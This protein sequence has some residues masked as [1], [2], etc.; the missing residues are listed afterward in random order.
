[1]LR[2]RQSSGGRRFERL[3]CLLLELAGHTVTP[4]LQHPAQGRGDVD[5][6]KLGCSLHDQLADLHCASA[7]HYFP[8]EME[9]VGVARGSSAPG[10]SALPL[11]AA[12]AVDPSSIDMSNN[13][14]GQESALNL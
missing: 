8:V 14:V 11:A 1:V 13:D 6:I 5:V 12:S 2:I 10:R 7:V 3:Q 4:A 9:V